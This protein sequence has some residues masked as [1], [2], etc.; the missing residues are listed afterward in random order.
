[1]KAGARHAR[2]I[3]LLDFRTIPYSTTFI[4]YQL[5]VRPQVLLSSRTGTAI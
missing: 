1:M 4:L 5:S 2:R 3:A